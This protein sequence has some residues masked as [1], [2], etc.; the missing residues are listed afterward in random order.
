MPKT[1]MT[2]A[3]ALLLAGCG[4]GA[5]LPVAPGGFPIASVGNP[6]SQVAP[7]IPMAADGTTLPGATITSARGGTFSITLP[8]HGTQGYGWVLS[9]AYDRNV[10]TTS[11]TSRLGPAPSSGLMGP[12]ASEI[13]DFTAG[14]AGR[15]TVSFALARFGQQPD[16]AGETRAFTIVV[17]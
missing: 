5:N 17:P 16:P 4:N 7:Q 1:P 13:F 14:S 9:S 8:G 12:S 15:T 6:S 10:A 3:A 2:L 11:G